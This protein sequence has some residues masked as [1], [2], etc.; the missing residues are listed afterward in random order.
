MDGNECRCSKQKQPDQ[1]LP[2]IA[3]TV[4]VCPM[5]YL[6]DPNGFTL[7]VNSCYKQMLFRFALEIVVPPKKTSHYCWLSE[8][9]IILRIEG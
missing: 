5:C 7:L 3:E 2:W 1:D 9:N 6:E 8:I 4:I